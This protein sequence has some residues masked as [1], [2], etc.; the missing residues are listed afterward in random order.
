MATLRMVRDSDL[1]VVEAPNQSVLVLVV[2]IKANVVLSL[3]VQ[4]LPLFAVSGATVR[5]QICQMETQ[6]R[7]NVHQILIVLS[8][9]QTVQ[10]GVIA[11][12]MVEKVLDKEVVSNQN[13]GSP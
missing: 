12:S 13:H 1:V 5:P 9:L 4:V 11:K 3:I 8:G 10:N 7:E 2:E 6:M